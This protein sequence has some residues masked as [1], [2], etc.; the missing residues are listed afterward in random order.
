V[1]A[2]RPTS[3]G[4]IMSRLARAGALAA[5]AAARQAQGRLQGGARAS[6]RLRRH[7]EEMNAATSMPALSCAASILELVPCR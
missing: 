3:L 6:R 5:K 1:P 2:R 4:L 7:E